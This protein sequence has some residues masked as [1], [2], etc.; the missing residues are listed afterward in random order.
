MSLYPIPIFIYRDGE[1]GK[2]EI[3]LLTIEK[4]VSKGLTKNEKE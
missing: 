4:T 3:P 1:E 2:N